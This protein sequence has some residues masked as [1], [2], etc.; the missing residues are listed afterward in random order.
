VVRGEG[1]TENVFESAENRLN[2]IVVL[3]VLVNDNLK[4]K[5]CE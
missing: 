5:M 4:N 2:E 3:N 1:L